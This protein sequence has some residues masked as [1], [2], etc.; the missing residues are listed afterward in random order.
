MQN[1]EVLFESSPWFILLSLLAGA[2]YAF[3]LYQKK[4][5]WSKTTN[6]LLAGLRFVL[7]TVICFLL[8][9]PFIKQIKNTFEDPTLIFAIDN[10]LSLN[11][12]MDSTAIQQT[13]AQLQEI[14]DQLEQTNYQIEVRTFDEKNQL[15]FKDINFDHTTTNL[16]DLLNDVQND[17][18]GRKL[19][20]VVMLTDGIY[21]IGMSPSYKLYNFSVFPVGLGDTTEKSDVNLRTLYYNKI[22]YQGNK[23]PLVAEV[24]NNGFRGE[25]VSVEVYQNE[26]LLGKKDLVLERDDQVE[27]VEFLLDAE[28]KGM[29]HYV[30]KITENPDEFTLKNNQLH[31]Y[32]EVIEGK[33][34]I[35]LVAPAPH[36]DIKAIRSAIETNKNYEFVTYIPSLD[37]DQTDILN[38]GPSAYDLVIFH[39][40][41]NRQNIGTEILDHFLEQNSPV[42]FLVGNQTDIQRFN[43]K[44]DLLQISVINNEKDNVTPVFNSRFTRFK[45]SESIQEVLNVYPPVTV[46]FGRL[47]MNGEAEVILYQRIGNIA[48]NKPLL[49]INDQPQTKSAILLGDG[50]WKWR[51]QEYAQN[52]NQEIFDELILKLVQFLSAKEDKRRFRVYPLKNEYYDTESVV[53]E[54]EVYNE[55][56]EQ[57]YG[58]RVELVITDEFGDEKSYTYV[59]NENNTRYTISGLE[60]GI[61]QYNASTSLDGEQVTSS[62]E[63]SVQQLQ[64][65]SINLTANH[66]LLR[67]MANQSGGKFY[68]PDQLNMLSTDF[69]NNEIQGTM[70]SNEEFLPIINMKWIFFLLLSL[71]SVEWFIRKYNSGY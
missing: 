65:E 15:N 19:A 63:F 16:S 33:E 70:Y 42:L 23:F 18:E 29:Q 9:G 67:S 13:M 14:R 37:P 12:V 54:T 52:E 45:L 59:T 53:F 30:V 35:L 4:G 20:G 55:I 38:A 56:Y 64:V 2:L 68:L 43:T 21:N 27:K 34:K 5:P 28:Q 47:Q 1:I 36:P 31:A 61:Y 22:T 6:Y 57:I 41:P 8:L 39:Q 24:V 7:V 51:L 60:Q 69:Q 58:Q 44:N 17:Y 10:S 3:V 40:V 71:I 25:L 48:T 32:I 11:E 26:Q 46:P 66:D 49:V 50:L 62:G